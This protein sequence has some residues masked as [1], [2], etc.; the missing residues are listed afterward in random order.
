MSSWPPKRYK[1]KN[2]P[3]YHMALKRCG[4]LSIWFDPKMPWQAA[5]TDKRGRQPE[6]SYT[7]LGMPVI[8]LGR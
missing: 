7:A 2:W 8:E 5:P 3:S 6:F 4:S 1:T